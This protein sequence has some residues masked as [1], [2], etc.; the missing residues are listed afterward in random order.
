MAL[1]VCD[2]LVVWVSL[3]VIDWLCEGDTD[4]L[5]CLDA[6]LRVAIMQVPTRVARRIPSGNRL[7]TF[8]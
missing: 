2:W 5:D 8:P 4:A 7:L 1:D 6:L 3:G